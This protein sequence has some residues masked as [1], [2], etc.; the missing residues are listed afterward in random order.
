MVDAE[1]LFPIQL[2]TF[3]KKKGYDVEAINIETICNWR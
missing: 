2:V 1:H 3:M